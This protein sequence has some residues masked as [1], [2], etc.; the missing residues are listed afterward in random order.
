[1]RGDLSVRSARIVRELLD[2]NFSANCR[3][4]SL[5]LSA[6]HFIQLP[7]TFGDPPHRYL[8]HG[9]LISHKIAHKGGLPVV[10]GAQLSGFSDQSHLTVIVSKY[11]KR[12]PMQVRLQRR[13]VSSL[14][15]NHIHSVSNFN[16]AFSKIRD[17]TVI[18]C[19]DGMDR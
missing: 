19:K 10:E 11:R 17:R 2:E 18:L 6:H 16:F 7:K 14:R 15:C 4:P 13:L 9:A 3:W 8:V 1:M 5:R 12:T